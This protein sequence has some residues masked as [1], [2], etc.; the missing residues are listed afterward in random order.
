MPSW[1]TFHFVCKKALQRANRLR[2]NVGFVLTVEHKGTCVSVV[3]A[4]TC[5]PFWRGTFTPLCRGLQLPLDADTAL[6]NH[7][8]LTHSPLDGIQI[9]RCSLVWITECVGRV[10]SLKGRHAGIFKK[11]EYSS[12]LYRM[13]IRCFFMPYQKLKPS[14]CGANS[15]YHRGCNEVPIIIPLGSLAV[16]TSY[17]VNL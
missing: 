16:V 7:H 3:G 13:L 14:S 9:F 17:Y 2:Y 4:L 8:S 5:R 11:I 6:I 1:F 10:I 12:N 15:W